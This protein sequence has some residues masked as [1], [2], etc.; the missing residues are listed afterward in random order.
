LK[1]FLQG[2]ALSPLLVSMGFSAGMA[3]EKYQKP[4][5]TSKIQIDFIPP[6]VKL[7]LI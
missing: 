1:I 4:D 3:F 7:D 2:R 5:P 6:I